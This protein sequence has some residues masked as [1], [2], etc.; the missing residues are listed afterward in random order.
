MVL[1]VVRRAFPEAG[2]V[3]VQRHAPLPGRRLQRLELVPRRQLPAGLADRQLDQDAGQGLAHGFEVAR[4]HRPEALAD[5]HAVAVHQGGVGLLLVMREVRGRVHAEAR[6]PRRFAPEAHRRD[7]LR[8]HAA[9]RE[10][11]RLL[12]EQHGDLALEVLD[13]RALPVHVV[14]DLA[15]LAPGGELAEVLRG[16]AARE[17][18]D[19]ERAAAPQFAAL[20]GREGHGPYDGRIAPGLPQREGRKAGEGAI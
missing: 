16:A 17:V 7:P 2:A 8:H 11:C 4:Q 14:L 10:H 13:Q 12:A 9:R 6:D 20:G 3:H 18:G 5:R 15:R 19:D 1:A